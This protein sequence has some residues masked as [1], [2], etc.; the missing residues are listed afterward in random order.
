MEDI[1]V[2]VIII[3]P[4]SVGKTCILVNCLYGLFDDT[5]Q[6]TLGATYQSKLIEVNHK[7]V[8]L[9]IWDTAGAEQFRSLA[10]MYYRGAQA[11]IIVF[12][13]N[14][15]DSFEDVSFW[16][17]SLRKNAGKDIKILLIGNKIDLEK[18]RV[19]SFDAAN[20]MAKSI[21]A[22]YYET[23]AAT[24]ENIKEVFYTIAKSFAE[25]FQQE[26]TDPEGVS[27]IHSEPK[28]HKCCK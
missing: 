16:A 15:L 20:A 1:Q 23:S 14:D 27:I 11:A 26:N 3:G 6:P 17:D 18:E 21:G 24:G 12:A 8:G 25:I 28:K 13:I 19:V 7:N 22:S 2:K 4:T 5:V 10:P 9:Q